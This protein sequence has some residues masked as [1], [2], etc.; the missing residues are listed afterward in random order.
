M[1]IFVE[2]NEEFF[3]QMIKIL[4]NQFKLLIFV[5]SLTLLFIFQG[6]S[7]TPVS[8]TINDYIDIT[9]IIDADEI[10]VSD[11]SAFSPGDT[12]LI[13]Q[14]KG[15]AINTSN[16]ANFGARQNVYSAGKYEIIRIASISGNDITL[17][18]D[19][20]NTY[21]E[22]G[23]TQMVK[24]PGYYNATV[25]G[26]ITCP[27]WDTISGKGGVVAMI[28]G[29]KLTLEADI[30]VTG[31]GFNGA[32]AYTTSLVECTSVNANYYYPAGSDSAGYK[33]E[34]IATVMSTRK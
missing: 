8:G 2:S 13:I 18:N 23:H 17:A 34:S 5:F 29:N 24:I 26:D 27:E 33:G 16:D 22:N 4:F 12:V 15:L 6:K 30:D 28:V 25:T 19:M 21:D 3:H 14:M 11:A 31:K 20:T 7:Q 9:A 32:Q 1:S 10:T